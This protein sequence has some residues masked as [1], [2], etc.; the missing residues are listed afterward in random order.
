MQATLIIKSAVKLAFVIVAIIAGFYITRQ[1]VS[2]SAPVN[3]SDLLTRITLHPSLLPEDVTYLETTL[4]M[5]HDQLPEWSQYVEDAKPFTLIVDTH[6]GDQG[7][8]AIAVCCDG[9]GSGTITFG[10]HLGHSVDADTAEAQRVTFVGTLIHE[11][12]H[13]RDQRAGRGSKTNFKSCVVVEKPGL[14]M[15]LQVKQALGSVNLG[16]NYRQALEQQIKSEAGALKSRELWD[17]YCG[18]FEK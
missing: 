8:E 18:A 3:V 13:I 5:L 12:T 11:I 1:C 7:R 4:Q 16:D 9:N 17:L 14:E 15:Q 2:A 6:Q 10:H